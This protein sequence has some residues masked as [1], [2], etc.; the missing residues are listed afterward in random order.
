MHW[1]GWVVVGLALAEGGWLAFDGGRA[2]VAGDYVTPR[3]GQ[4]AGQLGPWASVVSALGMDPRSTLM[5]SIH[6]LLGSA[7]LVTAAC[8]V[9]RF[10]WAWSAMVV[11]AVLGL[12]YIPFGTLLSAIQIVLLLLP[13]LRDAAR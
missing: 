5:K 8:F 2:L 7:W 6:L 3:S 12:W 1:L 13:V 11:C 4:Y 10:S 9:M